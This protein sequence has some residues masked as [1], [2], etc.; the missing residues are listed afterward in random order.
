MLYLI[1]IIVHYL[2][3]LLF[4]YIIHTTIII[5]NKYLQRIL[6]IHVSPHNP[7][8]YK[9]TARVAL[10]PVWA[11]PRGRARV[12]SLAPKGGMGAERTSLDRGGT[13]FLNSR[14]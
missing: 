5:Y 4:N 10:K 8:F 11:P 1:L 3:T 12:W 14:T 2:H 9:E 13:K 7:G 6:N